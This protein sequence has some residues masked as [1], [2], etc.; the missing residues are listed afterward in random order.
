MLIEI[1][2]QQKQ[3]VHLSIIYLFTKFF[4]PMVLFAAD[5]AIYSCC[6]GD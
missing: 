5:Y 6:K 3:K 4:Q 1:Y 2:T